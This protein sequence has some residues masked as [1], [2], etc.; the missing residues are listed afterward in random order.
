[1]PK[2]SARK[3]RRKRVKYQEVSLKLTKK[4]RRSLDNYCKAR[5]TTRTKLIKKMIRP[6]INNYS[7]EIPEE[8]YVTENQLELFGQEKE[9]SPKLTL[10]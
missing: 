6:F 4:Q 5:Q 9:E 3:K 1:M 8:I 2:N 7:Q 10:F